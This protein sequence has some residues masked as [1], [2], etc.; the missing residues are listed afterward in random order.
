MKYKKSGW[1]PEYRKILILHQE[2]LPVKEI[3]EKVN[4]TVKY[5]YEIMKK[6]KFLEKKKELETK[7]IDKARAVF[8][9]HAVKAAKRIVQIADRGKAEDRIKLDASKEVL[10]QVGMKPIEVIETRKREY[11][12]EE[13]T[14]MSK[15][16]IEVEEVA[17]RL[18]ARDSKFILNNT[19][20]K[21]KTEPTS[22]T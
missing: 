20:A 7:I 3:A 19:D 9:E 5:V 14:S 18:A 16:L 11:T 22:S 15:T 21:T 13:L 6:D 8:E 1:T 10:Y 2:G 17:D 12:P 4:M